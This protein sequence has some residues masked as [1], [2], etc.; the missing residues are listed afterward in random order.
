MQNYEG[1]YTS[2]RN[3]RIQNEESTEQ[4]KITASPSV[5]T[6][7]STNKS[8]VESKHFKNR[9]AQKTELSNYNSKSYSNTQKQT[10]SSKDNNDIA[11]CDVNVPDA[12]QGD[13][14]DL[15][16][17]KSLKKENT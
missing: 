9:L 7:Q 10:I 8:S 13:T 3:S 16:N 5:F 6:L 4:D 14:L 17:R 15:I 2:T 12:N 1:K 11:H